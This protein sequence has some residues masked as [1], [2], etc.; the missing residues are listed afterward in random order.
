MGRPI[1]F[2]CFYYLSRNASHNFGE[3]VASGWGG[4]AKRLFKT[5]STT[6]V[7][8]NN[9]AERPSMLGHVTS[10]LHQDGCQYC[11]AA[12]RRHETMFGCWL[13]QMVALQEGDLMI[14]S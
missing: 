4:D 10:M 11:L 2:V 12:V 5:D 9:A 13:P 8:K 1:N 14:L 6:I 7:A 3:T